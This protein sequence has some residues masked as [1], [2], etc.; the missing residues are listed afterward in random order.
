MKKVK[1]RRTDGTIVE[2]PVPKEDKGATERRTKTEKVLHLIIAA[3]LIIHICSLF[4]PWVWTFLSALKEKLEFANGDP[5]ALPKKWLFSN[6][7]KAFSS[8]EVKGATSGE[9][10][11][12]GGMIWNSVWYVGINSLLDLFVPACTGYCLSKYNFKGKTLIY[13]TA[14]TCMTIPIIGSMASAFR[15]YKSLGIYD[16]PLYVIVS[17][18]GG[19]GG[20]FLIYYGY[21]KNISWSYAEATMMDGGGPFTIFFKIMLPQAMPLLTTYAITGAISSWN[22]YMT[23][24]TY[25]P[26][27]PNLATGLYQFLAEA[28]R[29]AADYPLFFA[30]ALISLIPTIIIFLTCSSKIM[31]SL[32]IGGLKG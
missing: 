15:I 10:T 20:T 26:S 30:G 18:M 25:M 32:S 29:E 19:F 3:V 13:T 7:V 8:L 9:V 2:I 31:T 6:F 1:I 12:F 5:L 16:T 17:S 14:I 23:F 4:L 24:I 27:W 11:T 21:F 28:K 22:D